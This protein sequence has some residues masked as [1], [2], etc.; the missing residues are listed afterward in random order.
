MILWTY[1]DKYPV[2]GKNISVQQVVAKSER[3]TTKA[4]IGLTLAIHNINQRKVFPRRLAL[5]SLNW[6]KANLQFVADAEANHNLALRRY[7]V[8]IIY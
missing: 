1:T 4:C 7:D 2:T 8:E 6:V 5:K 3:L